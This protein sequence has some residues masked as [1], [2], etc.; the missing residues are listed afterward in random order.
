MLSYKSQHW[1]VL[2]LERQPVQK[3]PFPV[4]NLLVHSQ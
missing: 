3:P 1:P 2:T 4:N